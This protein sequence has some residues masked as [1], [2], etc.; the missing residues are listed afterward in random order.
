MFKRKIEIRGIS[1]V[2]IHENWGRVKTEIELA[3]SKAICRRLDE[4]EILHPNCKIEIRSSGGQFE[5]IIRD[6]NDFGLERRF[7][8]I[9]AIHQRHGKEGRRA[10]IRKAF[11]Y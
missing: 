9:E 8:K 5:L 2:P 4:E 1:D 7:K 6:E 10:E 11:L 3:R